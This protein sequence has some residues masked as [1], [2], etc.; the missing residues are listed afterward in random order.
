MIQST[1]LGVILLIFDLQL[2]LIHIY[3]HRESVTI[4]L[5]NIPANFHIYGDR[6]VARRQVGRK[7]L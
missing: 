2:T 3:R 4:L 6:Y 7:T 5:S 1:P